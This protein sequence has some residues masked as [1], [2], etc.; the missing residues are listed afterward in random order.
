MQLKPAASRQ[1]FEKTAFEVFDEAYDEL[2]D[3]T[4]IAPGTT[5]GLRVSGGQ[6][7]RAS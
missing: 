4:E 7:N 6:L 2:E 1:T 3:G 5:L